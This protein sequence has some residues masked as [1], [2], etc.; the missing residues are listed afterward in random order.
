MKFKAL[1][2]ALSSAAAAFSKQKVDEHGVVGSA[3]YY[4]GDVHFK[5]SGKSGVQDHIDA[6]EHLKS[7][8]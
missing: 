1:L 6:L 5:V 3:Y 7:K 2:A 8:E 4:K